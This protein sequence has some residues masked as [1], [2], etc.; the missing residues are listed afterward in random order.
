MTFINRFLLGIYQHVA[1]LKKKK[2]S[3]MNTSTMALWKGV[4]TF[5]RTEG[6]ELL[7]GGLDD[8]LRRVL[9]GSGFRCGIDIFLCDEEDS[10]L[11]IA[12][13]QEQTLKPVSVQGRITSNISICLCFLLNSQMAIASA[14]RRDG[15]EFTQ[16]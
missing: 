6:R 12:E 8:S 11:Q 13:R 16:P 3:N 14:Q 15:R 4:E 2:K 7:V 9:Q 1:P 10:K 5:Q